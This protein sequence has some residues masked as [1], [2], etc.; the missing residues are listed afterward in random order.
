[1]GGGENTS[2]DQLQMDTITSF[3]DNQCWQRNGVTGVLTLLEQRLSVQSIR[4]TDWH[5]L[6]N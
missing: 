5:F 4:K 3:S 6:Q 2:I 1:M